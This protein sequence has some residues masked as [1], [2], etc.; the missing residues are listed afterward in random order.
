MTPEQDVESVR[1]AWHA[2]PRQQGQRACCIP[3][4]ARAHEYRRLIWARVQLAGT[5][6]KMA[7]QTVFGIRASAVAQRSDPDPQ[8]H[9]EGAGI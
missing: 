5:A 9:A 1:L 4:A 7:L 3:A 6:R 8:I 2:R